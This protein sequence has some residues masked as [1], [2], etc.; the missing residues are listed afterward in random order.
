MVEEA[1]DFKERIS[2]KEKSLEKI[3]NEYSS[4]EEEE[5]TTESSD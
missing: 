3:R 5:G 4:S 1:K 2:Q